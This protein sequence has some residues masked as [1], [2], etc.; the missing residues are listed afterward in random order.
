MK[1]IKLFDN[2]PNQS[3]GENIDVEKLKE[4]AG[5]PLSKLAHSESGFITYPPNVKDADLKDDD[6]IFSI[7]GSKIKT[8]NVMGFFGVGEYQFQICSRFDKD[9]NDK[10]FFLHYM[11]QRVC[12]VSFAP[13]TTASENAFFDFIYLL[14][15]SY[16]HNAINQGI[17]RAY[18]TREYNDSNVRGPIDMARH[19][20][21]N[22][23][24]NGKVAYHTREYSIDN[25]LTQLIR[26]TIEC[27][28]TRPYGEAILNGGEGNS[29]RDDVSAIIASTPS[30]CK[31][32]L[33]SV[34]TKNLNPV[35]HPYYTAYE[36]L[37]K[38]CL[39][40]LSHQKLSYG[41]SDN[42]S[43]AGILFDGASLWEEYLNVILKDAFKDKFIHPN[44]R[45]KYYVQYTF[46]RKDAKNTYGEIY[47]DFLYNCTI[48]DKQKDWIEKASCILDAKYKTLGEKTD[49]TRNVDGNDLNQM[50][51][52]MV[53]FGCN[54]SLILHPISAAEKKEESK[55]L[56]YEFLGDRSY[57]VETLPFIVPTYDEKDNYKNFEDNM[58]NA[59]EEFVKKLKNLLKN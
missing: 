58:K 51:V 40:I 28:R 34:I 6:C 27:I 52:Y 11:L 41:N 47:P 46:K 4:I 55:S 44:N 59:E 48:R 19:I 38:L 56:E 7:D 29:T 54:Q 43:I 3:I 33:H 18:I 8:G 32:N 1:P 45:T 9:K 37:R 2:T 10:N 25:A 35:T 57:T 23:P 39:A 49:S 14:F 15:P 50:L 17:F 30:F 12:N 42:E 13:E 31:G 16:L 20:R 53:R 22:I 26:H 5:K 36:P 21:Y 24:F